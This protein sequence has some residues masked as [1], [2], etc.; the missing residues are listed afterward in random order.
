MGLKTPW[1]L[2]EAFGPVSVVRGIGLDSQVKEGSHQDQCIS[3]RSCEKIKRLS[4][5]FE[6]C[7][8][9][10][11]SIKI[12][13]SRKSYFKHFRMRSWS[14]NKTFNYL[15]IYCGVEKWLTRVNKMENSNCLNC[16]KKLKGLQKKYCS[17]K[18]K[19]SFSISIKRN[20]FKE[21]TGLSLQSSK[22]IIKKLEL[23]KEFGGGCSICGYN[24]N[25]S[26]LEFHHIDPLVKSF[27]LDLRTLSNRSDIEIKKELNK[28]ILICSNC[29]QELHYPHLD[30]EKLS[31]HKP[32]IVGSNPTPATKDTQA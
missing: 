22:G 27:T 15:K 12:N 8:V 32:E 9:A 13:R 3:T 26:A 4:Y 16:E 23:I 25:I 28:C 29:H 18:C 14:K 10:S 21:N 19:Q 7:T 17:K 1:F 5:R 6:S 30:L 20:R 11:G 31:E 2:L 24:K